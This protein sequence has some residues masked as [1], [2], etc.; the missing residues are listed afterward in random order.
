MKVTVAGRV[1]ATRSDADNE[2]RKL[3]KL[4]VD[5]I[6]YPGGAEFAFLF[7]Y[8]QTHTDAVSKIGPGVSFFRVILNA[9]GGG[10]GIEVA[11]ADGS[12]IGFSYKECLRNKPKNNHASDFASTC[13]LEIAEQIS[14]FKAA[15]FSTPSVPCA[16]CYKPV[17]ASA[18]EIDHKP[19]NTFTVLVSE[20]KSAN[21]IDPRTVLYSPSV[22]ACPNSFA[23]RPLALAWQQYHAQNAT[24][25]AIHKDC[26]KAETKARREAANL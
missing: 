8:L 5:S 3:L 2:Y 4:P 23:D 20:F 14:D 26:H 12:T 25:Q 15:A 18:C 24:L 10:H 19:P 6:F 1:F 16:V 21:G 7:G 9:L 22:P 13:R 17:S 11:R